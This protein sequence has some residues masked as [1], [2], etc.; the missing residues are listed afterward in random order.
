MQEV[1]EV[2]EMVKKATDEHSGD[3][4]VGHE[5][6]PLPATVAA[7]TTCIKEPQAQVYLGTGWDDELMEG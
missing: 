7:M 4:R 6:A 3:H 2:V 5:P 1:E